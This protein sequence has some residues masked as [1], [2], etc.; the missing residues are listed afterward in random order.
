MATLLGTDLYRKE[1]AGIQSALPAGQN[2]T[3]EHMQFQGTY[4]ILGTEAAADILPIVKL[5]IGAQLTSLLVSTDAIGGTTVTFTG[6]GDA[7]SAQ[8]YSSTA[9]PLTAAQSET[10]MTKTNAICVTPFT[11]DTDANATIL[12]VFGGTLPA[13]AGK[14]ITFRGFFRMP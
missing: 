7:G 12:A 11:I 2:L 10:A 14:K 6:I 8:R 9:I 1:T 3:G 13:T 4:T 5:P